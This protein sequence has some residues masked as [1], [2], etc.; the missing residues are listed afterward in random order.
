MC[1][2]FHP[3]STYLFRKS[4]KD[5]EVARL[6]DAMK[7]SQAATK[8]EMDI[9]IAQLHSQLRDEKALS[10]D[11]TAQLTIAIAKLVC[12][13]PLDASMLPIY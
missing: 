4:A 10:A 9:A 6:I 2:L 13:M 3:K 1:V 8:E 11:V 5:V 12:T 7:N